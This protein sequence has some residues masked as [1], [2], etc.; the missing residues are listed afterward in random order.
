MRREWQK[1]VSVLLVILVVALL[2]RLIAEGAWFGKPWDILRQF[3]VIASGT[4][5]IYLIGFWLA[6]WSCGDARLPRWLRWPRWAS[7]GKS[8]LVL[9]AL[10]IGA[11]LV[12][13]LFEYGG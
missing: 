6:D 3:S 10:I 9:G 1:R 2:G 12:A 13:I 4:S 8:A 7:V 11:P 5:A